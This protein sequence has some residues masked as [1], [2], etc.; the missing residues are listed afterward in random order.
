VPEPYKVA[1]WH[2]RASLRYRINHTKMV[3]CSELIRAPYAPYVT[4]VHGRSQLN[5]YLAYFRG[6]EFK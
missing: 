1:L 3:K 2:L 6:P 5:G 4:R